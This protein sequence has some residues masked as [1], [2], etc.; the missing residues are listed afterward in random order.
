MQDIAV[1]E[2]I[3]ILSFSALRV[4]NKRRGGVGKAE[5]K[6][7]AFWAP[8][9]LPWEAGFKPRAFKMRLV[10]APRFTSGKEN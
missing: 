2:A 5:E 4:Q 9:S 7:N 8:I 3:R 6:D 10:H 1:L